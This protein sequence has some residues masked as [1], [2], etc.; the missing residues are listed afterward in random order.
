MRCLVATDDAATRD[1][2]ASAVKSFPDIDV[3]AAS[4]D[5][6]RSLIRRRRFDFGFFTL[7]SGSRESITLWEELRALDAEC[8]IVALSPRS[9]MSSARATEVTTLRPFAR[10]GTPIDSVEVYGTVRRLLDRLKK[11]QL[12]PS[13]PESA[14]R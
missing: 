5:D 3:D 2:V 1:T 6:A 14:P 8:T 12:P 13:A 9:G 7:K 4:V 11:V 10:L